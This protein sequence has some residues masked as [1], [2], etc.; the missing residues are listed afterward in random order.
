MNDA[1]GIEARAFAALDRLTRGGQPLLIALSGGGDSMALLHLA[2]RWGRAPLA[3]VTLDHGLRPASATEA[4][5]AAAACAALGVPHVTLAWRDRPASGNLMAA[6]R[7]AR[8]ALISHHARGVVSA[9]GSV[10]AAVATGHTRDDLAET[11]LMRLARGAGLDGLAAMREVRRVHGTR[12][13]RPLLSLGRGALRDWLT[14]QGVAWVDDPTNENLDYDR[15]RVRAAIAAAG[16]DSAMLARSALNLAYARMA[17]AQAALTLTEGAEARDMALSLPLPPLTAAAP[18]LRRRVLVA[19]LRWVSGGDYPPRQS[20][21]DHVWTA[22]RQGHRAT[23]DGVILTPRADRLHLTREPAAATRAPD[24]AEPGL[25][26]RRWHVT[27]PAAH[28][29]RALPGS[30]TPGLWHGTG[31][32]GPAPATPARDLADFRAILATGEINTESH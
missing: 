28:H 16:L 26:D 10:T 23:L 7:A 25:W 30:A 9:A 15:A 13:L 18:E 14:A 2:H 5:L 29:I 22:L 32:L 4:G 21:L 19:A 24:C 1:A 27:P 3:A 12:W 17:L 8:L 11:L 20:G 31:C 6:A